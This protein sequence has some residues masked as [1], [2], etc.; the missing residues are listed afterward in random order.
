MLANK[1]LIYNNSIIDLQIIYKSNDIPNKLKFQKWVKTILFYFQIQAQITIRLVDKKE[2]YNLNLKY[3]GKRRPT[4]ILSFSFEKPL[5]INLS[6]LGDLVI[7]FPIIQ[8]EA[9]EQ[10][11]SIEC[12]LAHMVVH[13]T[14]HLLGYDHYKVYQAKKM[15]S[16]EI[17]I[18]S[19]LGYPNPYYLDY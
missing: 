12:H 8:K 18:M 4:N 17:K 16:I 7:C 13:G 9:A 2:S 1:K 14:L 3:R 15:E 6:L 19:L 10:G 5:W 11:K